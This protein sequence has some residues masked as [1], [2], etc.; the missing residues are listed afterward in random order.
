MQP[1]VLWAQRADRLLLTIDL[2]QCVDPEIR[3][4]PPQ[5]AAARGRPP[6]GRFCSSLAALPESFSSLPQH[7][8]RWSCK[9]WQADLPRPRTQPCH[10]CAWNTG[11]ALRCWPAYMPCLFVMLQDPRSTTIS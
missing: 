10:G 1:M 4:V 5:S 3:S 2:Q 11:H 9:G 7:Q 6:L 8:Q